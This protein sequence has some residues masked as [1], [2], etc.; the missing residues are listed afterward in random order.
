MIINSEYAIIKTPEEV[1]F[2]IHLASLPRRA[3]AFLIDFLIILTFIWVVNTPMSAIFN[4]ADGG[5]VVKALYVVLMAFISNFYFIFIEYFYHGKTL[6]KKMLK[7]KVIDSD[8]LSLTFYQILI[9][10]LMRSIDTLPFFYGTAV[11]A[12]F[13]GKNNRRLGDIV[14]GCLVI[15][16]EVAPMPKIKAILDDKYNSLREDPLLVA[17]IREQTTAEEK[18]LLLQVAENYKVFESDAV[19]QIFEELAK[20]FKEK[21]QFSDDYIKNIS[22][23]KMIFNL[24]NVLFKK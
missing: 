9:R 17:R 11:L 6:G 23:Q 8:A 18:Q 14:A 12:M 3:S 7:I 24:I 4:I 22:D 15:C 19:L 1:E 10:N 5:G 2:K 16:D 21:F 13:F 20:Y